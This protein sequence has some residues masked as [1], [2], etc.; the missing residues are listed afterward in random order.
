MIKVNHHKLKILMPLFIALLFV[1]VMVLPGCNKGGGDPNERPNEEENIEDSLKILPEGAAASLIN[2]NATVHFQT[3]DNFSASDCWGGQ[4]AGQWPDAKKE[5][6]ANWLFSMDTNTQ[7]QPLGIGLSAWRFNIGAGSAEQGNASDISD[8]W[9]RNQC[10]LQANGGYDW[11]KQAGQQ[12]FL[13]AAKER[14][15]NNFIGFC[16]SPPVHITKNGKAYGSEEDPENLYTQK[17]PDFA[18]F[19][20]EVARG[21][22]NNTGIEL[23]YLSPVNEPQWDWTGGGQEGCH[24]KNSTYRQ[25]V[26]E[27]DQKLVQSE[28]STKILITE[29]GKWSYLFGNGIETG[30]QIDYFFGAGSPV[31]ES[32]ALA[33]IIAGHSYYSTTPES[34]LIG[35]RQNVWNKATTIPDLKVWSTEY[36]PLGNGDLQALGWSNWH[37]DLS[38]D[39]ALYVSRII[40]H[41][42]VYANASAWQWWLA[43]SPYNYPDGLIYISKNKSNGTYSDSKLMWV[44]GNYSRFVRPGAIRIQADCSNDDIYVTAFTHNTTGMKTIVV[45]NPSEETHAVKLKLEGI[46][47]GTV[48]P[49][50]TSNKDYHKLFPMKPVDVSNAFE[51][52]AQC[53][54]TFTMKN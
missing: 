29:A 7:G 25:L 35:D 50:I 40:H 27:L 43:I 37:Q 38:M 24:F 20:V 44:L 32:P 45:S 18:D 1:F 34:T 9:R 41:D 39:V 3:M 31:N 21:L 49:Y 47:S 6:M 13:T 17:L 42:L 10:F 46:S 8:E 16:N 4:F 54:L 22:K 48:R 51:I 12:W 33:K 30:N 23:T 36:C 26:E 14:G 28:L 15:V 2:I 52:P 5:A 11:S 19:L 53:V